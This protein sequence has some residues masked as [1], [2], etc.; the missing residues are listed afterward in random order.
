MSE[1]KT[2]PD[3]LIDSSEAGFLALKQIERRK[4]ERETGKTMGVKIQIPEVGNVLRPLYGGE[5]GF[6]LGHSGN[7]KSF[8]IKKIVNDETQ[9]FINQKRTDMVNVIVTWEETAEILAM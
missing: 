8:L 5:I 9:H 3:A 2:K 7:G 4:E 1:L 6:I